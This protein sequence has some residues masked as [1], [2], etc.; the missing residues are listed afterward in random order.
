MIVF[1]DKF[2]RYVADLL[3]TL[4]AKTP[5][6]PNQLTLGRFFIAAPV[7][8]YL[9]SR[10]DYVLNVIG[11]FS[12]ISL[13]ILDFVDGAL[14]RKTNRSSDVGKFLDDNLDRMLMLMVIFS[15]F[16]A[17]MMSAQGATWQI[18]FV[19]FLFFFFMLA[20]ILEDF[21][22][23]FNLELRT[24]HKITD[25]IFS[26]GISPKILD[27]ILSSFID[28]HKNSLTRFC[29]CISYPLVVGVLVNQLL[30]IFIF[31]TIMF[32]LRFLVIFLLMTVVLSDVSSNLLVIEALR[33]FKQ[34]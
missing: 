16:Y 23:L 2:R 14:A 9:F 20:N 7:S 1:L 24:F 26:T 3:A 31:I 6:T 33:K 12:Y 30:I 28:V 27:R 22:E 29:F 4:F 21:T 13:S 5:I 11:L 17:G 8:I 15:F 32:A 18:L 34:S 10:G 19:I 25:Y